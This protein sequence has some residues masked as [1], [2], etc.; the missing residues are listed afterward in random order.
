LTTTALE[1]VLNKY[2]HIKS[3]EVD[4]RTAYFNDCWHMWADHRL[5][6]ELSSTQV[7]YLR[8]YLRGLGL[9][10]WEDYIFRHGKE[11]RFKN[12]DDLAMITLAGLDL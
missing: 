6:V 7:L 3:F 1:E 9:Y 12:A 8:K 2:E 4:E 11:I 10:E 5:T